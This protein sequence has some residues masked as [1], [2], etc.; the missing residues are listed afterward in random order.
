MT[1]LTLQRIAAMLEMGSK[2]N[3]TLEISK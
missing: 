3:D 2:S 1:T